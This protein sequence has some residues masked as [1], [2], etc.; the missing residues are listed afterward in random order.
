MIEPGRNVQRDQREHPVIRQHRMHV[1]DPAEARFARR[2]HHLDQRGHA[3]SDS[4]LR[5]GNLTPPEAKMY[6]SQMPFQPTVQH[7]HR[8]GGHSRPITCM[9]AGSTIFIG[10]PSWSL[11]APAIGRAAGP[12]RP[13]SFEFAG[14]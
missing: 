11:K 4:N 13:I 10:I 1:A 2:A 8:N 9:R 7:L 5:K 3:C 6:P 12:F 14:I